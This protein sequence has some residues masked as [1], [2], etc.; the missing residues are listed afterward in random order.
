MPKILIKL[1]NFTR[2][3]VKLNKSL[4]IHAKRLDWILMSFMSH[5]K[6]SCVKRKSTLS[7]RQ[8]A[9]IYMNYIG[10]NIRIKILVY[11]LSRVVQLL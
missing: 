5:K 7:N 11:T 3:S 4:Q 2:I 8:C 6:Q 9:F 1:D 10:S